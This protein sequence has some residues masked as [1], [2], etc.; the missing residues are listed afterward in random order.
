MTARDVGEQFETQAAD[1]L[2]NLGWSLL[3]RNFSC[4]TGELDL[5]LRDPSGAIVFVEVKYRTRN[6]FGFGQEFVGWKKQRRMT[7]AA[8]FYIKARQLHGR[9]YRFDIIS[10]SP[11]GL[12][13]IQNAFSPDGYTL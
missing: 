1:F 7:L 13:H 2:T 3:D 12:D 5:I 4:R 9:N 11:A 8:L 10:I 6:D